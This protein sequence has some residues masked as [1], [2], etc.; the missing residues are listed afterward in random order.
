MSTSLLLVIRS[1]ISWKKMLLEKMESWIERSRRLW[2]RLG[3]VSISFPQGMGVV[4]FLLEESDE[5]ITNMFFFDDWIALHE[6]DPAFRAVTL[7][8]DNIKALVRDVKFHH[9]PVG[10][11][12][13]RSERRS[14]IYSLLSHTPPALQ[15]MVICKQPKI[16]GEGMFFVLLVIII[17][18][19]MLIRRQSQNITTRRFSKLDQHLTTSHLPPCSL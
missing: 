5:R 14:S 4:F 18:S 11:Y 1:G 12:Y 8:N 9:D 10:Q 7:E 3:M 2:I 15:S 6:L 16:G 17:H 19:T 13:L